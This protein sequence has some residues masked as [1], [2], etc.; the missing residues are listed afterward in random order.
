MGGERLLPRYCWR[1]FSGGASMA[2]PLRTLIPGTLR[3][4][5]YFQL[6][7]RMGGGLLLKC[8]RLLGVIHPILG[9]T[10]AAC[11]FA[12]LTSC[13]SSACSIHSSK[14]VGRPSA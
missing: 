3:I 12:E 4:G 2:E 9:G 8:F 11:I 7:K 10:W 1:W 13:A 14:S 6:R 5:T